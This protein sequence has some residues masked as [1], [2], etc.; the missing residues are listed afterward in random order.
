MT[1]KQRILIGKF[2]SNHAEYTD[3]N[4]QER[5]MRERCKVLDTDAYYL[6]LT[7]S[8]EAVTAEEIAYRQEQA[9]LHGNISL[10]DLV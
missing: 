8:I 9:I 1:D 6:A 5:F 10:T 4:G 2:I 7:K 3:I